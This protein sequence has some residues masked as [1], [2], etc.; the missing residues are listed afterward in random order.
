LVIAAASVGV[1]LVVI[2]RLTAPLGHRFAEGSSATYSPDGNW[3]VVTRG[4]LSGR[5]LY[6]EFTVWDAA[7]LEKIV[8][9]NPGG[10]MTHEA[11]FTSD[12]NYLITTG[13]RSIKIW[14]TEEWDFL[15]KVSFDGLSCDLDVHP[16]EN[17]IAVASCGPA[18]NG[19]YVIDVPSQTIV[20]K[21]AT[22]HG[23]MG[24]RIA[25]SASGDA[26]AY[27][28][29]V[30]EESSWLFVQLNDGL[31][32]FTLEHAIEALD[33]SVEVL[34][35]V[36]EDGI[37]LSWETGDAEPIVRAEIDSPQSIAS[38]P[39]GQ[40]LAVGSEGSLIVYDVN[41]WKVVKKYGRLNK[42]WNIAFS[43]D[44][45]SM[46]FVHENHRRERLISV[47]EADF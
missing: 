26:I 34:A 45:D 46:V 9:I 1:M 23:G 38:S 47:I 16:T 20:Q 22:Y 33:W 30:D 13:D 35:I 5:T 42:V 7:T 3:I 43:P 8:G 31:Q 27:S 11:V 10:Y 17:L 37:L 32:E 2:L 4:G 44:G 15:G 24:S 29:A 40:Y 25:Y 19:F 41:R 21:L 6:P 39:D 12:G 14:D 28:Y 18:Q 36:T